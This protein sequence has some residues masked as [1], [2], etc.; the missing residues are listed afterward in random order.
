MGDAARS[1][2]R[3]RR[4]PCGRSLWT[5]R[6][7]PGD[8]GPGE[9]ATAAIGPVADRQLSADQNGKA[10]AGRQLI[11]RQLTTNPGHSRPSVRTAA[12]ARS[13]CLKKNARSNGITATRMSY[14]S[15]S[16]TT[17]VNIPGGL[18]RDRSGPYQP[19]S[20]RRRMR[21]GADAPFDR[22]GGIRFP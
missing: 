8:G 4:R 22:D 11:G 12:R 2:E 10:D 14:L 13:S 18:L 19:G 21:S 15:K 6:G 1:H 20:E 3:W 16:M 9:G 17:P 5:H 7:N